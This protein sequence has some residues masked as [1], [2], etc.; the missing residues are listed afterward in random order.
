[1]FIEEDI[2]PESF[3]KRFVREDCLQYYIDGVNSETQEKFNV[4]Y[5]ILENRVVFSIRNEIGQLLS[6]KGRTCYKN[7][8]KDDIPKFISY[9]PSNNNYYLFGFYE[10]RE[11]IKVSN[12][13]Y[14]CEA[15]KGVMQ[16][17]SMMINNAISIN[18]KIISDVQLKKLF[19]L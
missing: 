9:Y 1:M 2:L 17:D 12:E 8:T 16:L 11:A 18:K 10:N 5:D 15:E 13:I 6:F 4:C 19:K 14:A 3:A 7:Y